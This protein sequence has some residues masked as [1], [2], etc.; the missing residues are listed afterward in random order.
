MLEKRIELV[1]TKQIKCGDNW[2]DA[3]IFLKS[4]EQFYYD[5]YVDFDDIIMPKKL[6]AQFVFEGHIAPQGDFMEIHKLSAHSRDYFKE[7][8]D[9]TKKY[10]E[11]K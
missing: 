6:L 9:E 5:V 3:E 11:R 1:P 2:Y 10:I 8:M 7:L 4:I